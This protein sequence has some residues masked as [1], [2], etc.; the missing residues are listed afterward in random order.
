MPIVCEENVLSLLMIAKSSQHDLAYR[1]HTDA[2]DASPQ[3]TGPAGP[4]IR[5]AE[6][7]DKPLVVERNIPVLK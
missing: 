5:L 4:G 7:L 6:S 2:E 1:M 3:L